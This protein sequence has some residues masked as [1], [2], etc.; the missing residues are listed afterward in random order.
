M[1]GADMH[2]P[3]HDR[4]KTDQDDAG[5]KD[6]GDEAVDSFCGD[7]A[8]H[9][10]PEHV[11]LTRERPRRDV[12]LTSGRR[13]ELLPW[14][15]RHSSRVTQMSPTAM[16]RAPG[17]ADPKPAQSVGQ[18]RARP[19]YCHPLRSKQHQ[20]RRTGRLLKEGRPQMTSARREMRGWEIAARVVGALLCAAVAY[21][22]IKDQGGI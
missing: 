18:G 19:L 15:V 13:R 14:I 16:L 5:S 10:P 12:L 20:S 7:Y 2:E 8:D 17:N 22:H 1:A 3:D 9:Q 4:D 6:S 21:I 11:G